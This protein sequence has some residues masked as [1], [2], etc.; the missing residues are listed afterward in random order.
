MS[1]MSRGS[2]AGQN[3]L[4]QID[5]GIHVAVHQYLLILLRQNPIRTTIVTVAI[6]WS[7]GHDSSIYPYDRLLALAAG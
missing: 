7:D 3:L 1:L 4:H 2:R 6:T 5:E